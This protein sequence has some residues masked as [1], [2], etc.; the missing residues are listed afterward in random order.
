MA[1]ERGTQRAARLRRDA[2]VLQIGRVTR[3]VV[4]GSIGLIGVFSAVAAH[5]LPGHGPTSS[6]PVSPSAGTSSSG[7][8][9]VS[10][11]SGSG[12]AIQSPSQAPQQTQAPPVAVSGGS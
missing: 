1:N 12:G 5:A 7:V 3:W 10:G 11:V 4:A 9:G 2:G 6:T 8:S